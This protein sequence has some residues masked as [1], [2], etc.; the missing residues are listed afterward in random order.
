M[1]GAKRASSNP[2]SLI[3]GA[4]G[5]GTGSRSKR[6]CREAPLGLWRQAARRGL[7]RSAMPVKDLEQAVQQ[8][9]GCDVSFGWAKYY[10][11]AVTRR[12][13]G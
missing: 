7:A 3:S 8:G 10:G 13:S 12:S 4:N 11:H 2:V 6:Q 5:A 1:P 9:I